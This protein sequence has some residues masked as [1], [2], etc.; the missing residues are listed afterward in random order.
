MRTLK[1]AIL[2]LLN[3]YPMTGY[4]ISKEFDK[5]LMN[6]WHAKHSQIYPELKKLT[7]EELVQ[8]E[9]QI[10]GEILEKKV[11]SITESGKECLIQWLLIE[12]SLEPTPKDVFK[13]RMY[14]SENISK[15]QFR[16]LIHDQYI[17]RLAKYNFLKQYLEEYENEVAFASPKFGDYM[18]LLSANMREKSYLEWLEICL[19][20]CL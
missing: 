2:G 9:I 1:Y 5:G 10:T 18:V 6:F 12:E 11:Y 19:T 7:M 20:K 8:F 17:K 3:R 13:L 15:E 16:N 14:F 4:D